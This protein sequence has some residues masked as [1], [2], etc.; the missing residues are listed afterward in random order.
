MKV[1]N[2]VIPQNEKLLQ[3]SVTFFIKIQFS[4]ALQRSDFFLLIGKLNEK[5]L[6]SEQS[7]ENIRGNDIQHFITHNYLLLYRPLLNV[8]VQ[9]RHFI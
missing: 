3:F 2:L 5:F 1:I 6:I 9:I 4:S 7:M 8:C